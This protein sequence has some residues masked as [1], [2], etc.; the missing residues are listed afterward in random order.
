MTEPSYPAARTVAVT[1]EEHFARYFA[2]AATPRQDRQELARHPDAQVIEAIIDAAFWSSLRREEGFSPKISLAFLPPEDAGQPLRFERHLPLTPTTLSRL[3]PAVERP[4]IHLGIWRDGHELCVWGTTRTI[5]K[6][7]F[8]L[9]VIEPGLLVV[10]YRRGQDTGK[11]VNVVVL[12]GD[13]IK[14]LD[15]HGTRLTDCPTPLSNLLTFGSY[16]SQV[17]S[18]N[19]LVQLA[20]SMRT[21]GRGGSLL[22]VPQGSEA[23]RESIVQPVSYSV[24]PA[25]SELAELMRQEPA[26]RD[27]R[28]WQEAF[29]DAVEAMAGLTA[30]DGATVISD[31]YELLAFGAKIGRRDGGAQVEQVIVTEPIVG[32]AASVVHPAQLGGTRHLSA[33]QFVQDQRESVSL[34]ASQDGRFTVF[35]WSPCEV[36]VHAHRVETLL[37]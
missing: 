17:E 30:V 22:V 18:V 19:V 31:Q 32:G 20:A 9:E 11:F 14:V 33:A 4:G 34:V 7:C 12:K 35:A 5:P 6:F 37:L 21:H 2:A 3:A 23:W 36:M 8:V 15:E 28:L 16:D 27:K 10:K 24:A 29:L 1:V 25:Y 26:E 13:Q